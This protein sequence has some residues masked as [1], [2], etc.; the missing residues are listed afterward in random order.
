MQHPIFFGSGDYPY[1][2]YSGISEDEA[3]NRYQK[4]KKSYPD[5]VIGIDFFFDG[6]Q[7]KYKVFVYE[8]EEFK[9]LMSPK[10]TLL[11][12]DYFGVKTIK[13]GKIDFFGRKNQV[14]LR[15]AFYR[16]IERELLE[17]LSGTEKV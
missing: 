15:P 9:K 16:R 13:S 2:V 10:E 7:L 8:D 3:R 6:D 4:V 1:F 5:C 14:I 12:G 11:Y 17:L